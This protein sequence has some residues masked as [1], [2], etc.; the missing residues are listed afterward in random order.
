MYITAPP[1]NNSILYIS[2][3]VNMVA[4]VNLLLKKKWW[5]Y[6]NLIYGAYIRSESKSAQSIVAVSANKIRV[7]SLYTGRIARSSL[8]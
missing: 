3:I 6:V 8:R 2:S 4:F 7:N 1:V 5:F